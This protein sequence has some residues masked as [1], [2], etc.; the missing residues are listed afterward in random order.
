[1]EKMAEVCN[2]HLEQF[3]KFTELP[4]EQQTEDNF[5]YD[6]HMDIENQYDR[7]IAILGPVAEDRFFVYETYKYSQS[8]SLRPQDKKKQEK[9]SQEKE[10]QIEP[11]DDDDKT[12]LYKTG[13]Q[14]WL[15]FLKGCFYW[16]ATDITDL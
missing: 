7:Y 11:N 14:D 5:P 4:S 1:M 6:R 15:R 13:R 3:N 12:E 8:Q 16:I 9:E 10:S 2:T